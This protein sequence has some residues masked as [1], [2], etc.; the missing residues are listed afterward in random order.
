MPRFKTLPCPYCGQLPVLKTFYRF[1]G[2]E[3]D[4][5]QY[6][7]PDPDTCDFAD[8]LDSSCVMED[9][10]RAALKAWNAAAAN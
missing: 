9:T 2:Y 3:R 4:Q 10:K 6:E 1:E 7:H 8:L 5:Y